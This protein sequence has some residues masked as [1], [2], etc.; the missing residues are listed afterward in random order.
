MRKASIADTVSEAVRPEIEKLGLILWDVRYEKEGADRFLRIIIDSSSNV[1]TTDC[2]NVSRAVDPIIDALD[3]I[4][5]QYYLEVSS[6]GL[7]RRLT[8]P[9]HFEAY[10]GK[11]VR[12]RFIRPQQ[13]GTKEITGILSARTDDSVELKLDSGVNFTFQLKDISWVRACDDE[14]L[15][16]KDNAE[17]APSGQP[18]K[19]R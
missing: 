15:F 16:K 8:S 13:D 18:D 14:D 12:A 10:A 7:A 19:R 5:E 11:K 3:P 1:S 17:A 9:A 2:E 4:S 6:P